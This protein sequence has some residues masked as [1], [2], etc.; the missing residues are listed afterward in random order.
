MGRLKVVGSVFVLTIFLMACGN[1]S[2]SS[3]E[4]VSIPEDPEE[5]SG[6]ITVWAWE[7]EAN[8]LEQDVLPA[9]EEKYPNVNVTIEKQGVD[10]VYQ[11]LNAGFSGGGSGL[12]DVTQ[13]E[14]SRI[15]SFS[16]QFPQGFTNLSALGFEEHADK[17][18]EAK[19]EGLKDADGNIIAMP[20]DLGPVGVIYR[21]DIFE[22]AEVDPS[23]I[24]T[25]SDY[26]EAGKQIVDHTGE[27]MLGSYDDTLLRV[28]LQQQGTYYF[29]QDGNINVNSEEAQRALET[30]G[31][32][33]DEGLLTYT[34]DWDGHIGAM[35]NSTVATQP[36]AVWWGGTMIEQ[37]PELSG[38]WGM[39]PLPAFE[40]GGAR[41]ANNGG[42]ALAIPEASENKAAAYVFS[43]FATTQEEL[44]VQGIENRGLFPSLT[45][46]YESDY[47]NQ[48]QEY[49]NNQT[50]YSDFAETVEDIPPIN[51]TSDNLAARDIM[52]SQLEAFLLEDKSVQDVLSDSQEEIKS[53][54]GREVSE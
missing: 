53:Q 20:R 54:S 17:F 30:I 23:S 21:T 2:E 7:L 28:M 8:F 4:E 6:D 18:P 25:W 3:G 51:Y 14:N 35:K 24:E 48:Q 37:M 12:P 34:N 38:N 26:I 40:E 43:E 41:A 16:G 46:A 11:K 39:F 29:D 5:V 19:L 1:N 22:E 49:F 42:S 45:S 15:N 52:E 33:K 31:Q 47:F 36:D 32:M 13:I 10:Q 50:F 44:Q 27:Y 9:F